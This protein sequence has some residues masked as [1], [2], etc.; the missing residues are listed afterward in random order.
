MDE[1]QQHMEDLQK[2]VEAGEANEDTYD[3]MKEYKISLK[4]LPN[5]IEIQRQCSN[6]AKTWKLICLTMTRKPSQMKI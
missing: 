1:S 4:K 5:T 2:V 3:E 6:G